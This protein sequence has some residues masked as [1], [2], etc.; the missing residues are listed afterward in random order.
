LQTVEPAKRQHFEREM[1]ERSATASSGRLK[2]RMKSDEQPV[3]KTPETGSRS[4]SHL[5]WAVLTALAL[6]LVVVAFVYQDFL[7]D[8]RDHW[9]FGY[10]TGKIAYSLANGHGFSNPFW[11][12][13]GPTAILSPVF[14]YLMSWAPTPRRRPW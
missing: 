6:R 4:R 10:E 1:V 2:T 7:V 13:T 3:L 8:G 12:A 5:I 9:E 11:I 14:P